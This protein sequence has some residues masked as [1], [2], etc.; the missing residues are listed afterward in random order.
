V[1]EILNEPKHI[2]DDE[3]LAWILDG[4][5]VIT[6]LDSPDPVLSFRGR[7]QAAELTEQGGKARCFGTSRWTWKIND[8]QNKTADGKRR[9]RRIVRSKLVWMFDNKRC[10]RPGHKVHHD[11]DDRMNDSAE[12]LIE[13]HDDV[14]SAL[15]SGPLTEEF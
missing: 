14:H 3:L 15:H 4:T 9:T 2:S 12:N 10:V 7:V 6:E 11:D 13:L 8:S 5:I 1:G